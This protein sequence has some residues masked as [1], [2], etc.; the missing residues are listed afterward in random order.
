MGYMAINLEQCIF[1][2]VVLSMKLKN[3]HLKRFAFSSMSISN[4]TCSL[5]IK[6]ALQKHKSKWKTSLYNY[7]K[8]ILR[9]RERDFNQ[10]AL[11]ESI[12]KSTVLVLNRNLGYAKD[13]MEH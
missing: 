2:L 9:E 8:K 5:T 6:L 7:L 3:H 1:Q 11:L 4:T 12:K 10:E 13:E